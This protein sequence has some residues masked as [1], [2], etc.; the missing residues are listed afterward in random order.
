MAGC[1]GFQKNAMAVARAY[2]QLTCEVVAHSTWHTT[3]APAAPR[4][5]SVLASGCM[6]V[7]HGLSFPC[8][9]LLQ[10]RGSVPASPL[11]WCRCRVGR[12]RDSLGG[13]RAHGDE[14]RAQLERVDWPELDKSSGPVPRGQRGGL[15]RSPEKAGWPQ[16][17]LCL[18]PCE[19]QS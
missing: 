4:L 3:E 12:K 19:Q 1:H 17:S 16:T 15:S 13:G 9:A 2:S 6:R 8:V 5:T 18:E 11:G 10:L 14:L 7:E